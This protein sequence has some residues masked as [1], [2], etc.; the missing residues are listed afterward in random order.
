MKVDRI[1]DIL[2]ARGVVPSNH[3]N[4]LEY[5]RIVASYYTV[6]QLD[7]CIEDE[8]WTDWPH[9]C[10]TMIQAA[11]DELLERKLLG[12]KRLILK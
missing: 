12:K 1:W 5:M 7:T 2:V 4:K 6:K 10:P 3:T 9:T 11:K 8:V